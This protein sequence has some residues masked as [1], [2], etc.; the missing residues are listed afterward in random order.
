LFKNH[1]KLK[2]I[3]LTPA[4]LPV[5]FFFAVAPAAAQSLKGRIEDERGAPIAFAALYVKERQQGVTANDGGEFELAV[6]AGI[7]TCTFRCLGYES[8]TDTVAVGPSGVALRVVLTEKVYELD[9]V[10]ISASGEDPAYGIM[11]RVVARAPYFRQVVKEFVAQ[12]YIKGTLNVGEIKGLAGLAIDRTTKKALSN[13]SGIIESLNEIH[14]YAPDRYEHR[15]LSVQQAVSFDP[16]DFPMPDL[17]VGMMMIDIY[18]PDLRLLSTRAFADYRFVYEGEF[19]DGDRY[20]NKIRVVP[21]HRRD[22][23][24]SGTL[25][26]VDDLWSVYSFDLS[27]RVMGL[28]IRL[29]QHYSNTSDDVFLPVSSAAEVSGSI[30]GIRLSGRYNNSIQYSLIVPNAPGPP[31]AAPPVPSATA[32][33]ENKKRGKIEAQLAQIIGKDELTNSDMRRAANMQQQLAALAEEENRAERGEKKTLEVASRYLF[34]EDSAAR[35][36]D[37][38]YWRTIRPIPLVG[39]EVTTFRK[40]DSIRLKVAAGPDTTAAAKRRRLKNLPFQIIGGHTFRLDTSLSVT[41]KGLLDVGALHFN[42]VD[43]W[44]YGQSAS[45]TKRWLND[46]RLT[47]SAAAGWAFARQTVLWDASLTYHYWPQRRASWRL[48]AGHQTRD[49]AGERGIHPIVNTFSSLLFRVNYPAF[50]D[51][52]YIG[53]Q[54]TIDLANGLQWNLHLLYRDNRPVDNHSDASFFFHRSRAYRPNT[55]RNAKAA[56]RPEQLAANA[57]FVTDMSLAYTPRYYYRMYG[58][59]KRMLYSHYPTFTA[60]WQRGWSPQAADFDYLSLTVVQSITLHPEAK[61]GY[62]VGGGFFPRAKRMHFSDFRHFYSN[63]A[64]FAFNGTIARTPQLLP[65]YTFSTDE[66]WATANVAYEAG[67]IALK[68]LPFLSNTIMQERLSATALLT[69]QLRPYTEWGYGLTDIYLFGQIGVFAGFEGA[70][71]YGWGLRVAVNLN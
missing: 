3:W 69:P 39:N 65:A 34:S 58:N 71:Y 26:I 46:R 14:F 49:F 52:R 41:Y 50:Y 42:T 37:T 59:R 11:R 4:F 16:K 40:N 1:K 29:E 28:D 6:P 9:G 51:R 7:Y 70:R 67:F 31:T 48:E 61:V 60:R 64:G 19:K 2:K 25:Y 32:K 27:T 23:L 20:I 55:P 10:R 35:R 66:W 15:V 57:G 53:L 21:K 24:Y 43:G 18:N 38:A 44:V 17:K 47:V 45:L 33:K 56:E 30:M 8:T 12:V 22:D 54:H 5:I 36:R 13:S 62:T 63:E 68:Y